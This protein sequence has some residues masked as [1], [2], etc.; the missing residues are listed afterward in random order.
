MPKIAEVERH[1]GLGMSAKTS[2]DEEEEKHET[3]D[4][5]YDVLVR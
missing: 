1:Y 4:D 5:R 2:E 3:I